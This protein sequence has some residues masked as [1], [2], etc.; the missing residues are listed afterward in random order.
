MKSM[1]AVYKTVYNIFNQ[2]KS[3]NKQDMTGKQKDHLL[4]KSRKTSEQEKY[5]KKVNSMLDK[6]VAFDR[7]LE[8]CIRSTNGTK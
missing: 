5:V 6:V 8:K 2:K 1:A 3:W 7:K 4:K